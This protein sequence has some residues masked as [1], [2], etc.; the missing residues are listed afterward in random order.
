[1]GSPKGVYA[2]LLWGGPLHCCWLF[3]ITL[4]VW[5]WLD[6]GVFYVDG[7]LRWRVGLPW[8]TNLASTT[9]PLVTLLFQEKNFP[10]SLE[11]FGVSLNIFTSNFVTRAFSIKNHFSMEYSNVVQH[12]IWSW[13]INS[14]FKI[15]IKPM[16]IFFSDMW[17]GNLLA[18]LN[19]LW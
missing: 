19:H 16:T 3:C 10:L 1:M 15:S 9:P 17:Q 6:F 2:L 4:N 12:L 13:V 7:P 11:S 14:T 18:M 5:S 8:F